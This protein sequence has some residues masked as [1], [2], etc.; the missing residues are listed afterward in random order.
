MSEIDFAFQPALEQAKRIRQKE[1][2]PLELLDFYLERIE[3]Y[4]SRVGSY[5]TVM[6]ELAR[7]DAQAKTEQLAATND[8]ASLPPFFG[9]PLPIKDLNAVAQMPCSAGVAALRDQIPEYE[10]GMVTKLR[11]AGFVLLGKTATSQL[12]SMPYTE[13]DGFPPT[14]NP[15]H[16]EHTPGGSSGGAAAA[17][18]AG[19][20]PVAQGSDGGGSIRIPS[21]CCG[22]LG[23][24]PSRGRISSAPVGDRLHGM[25]TDGPIA[26]TVA[27]AAAML[28]A[29]SGYIWGD[30]Y[31][32]GQ[33]NPSFWEATHQATG[34]LRIAYAT[35]MPGL[36]PASDIAKQ[37]VLDT[38]QRLCELGHEATEA[39]PDF[40]GLVEPFTTIFAAAVSS[41][42]MAKSALEPINRMLAE[43]GEQI[44]AGEYLQSIRQL[45]ILAR[46]IVG[47][48]QDV[49]VLVLPVL[50]HPPIRVGEWSQLP[51][52]EILDRITRWI[53]PC[54]PF[55]ATGQPAI[56]LP[57]GFDGNGLPVSVQL[58]GKPAAEATLIAVASQLEAAY[59]WYQYYP[60]AFAG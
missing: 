37:A 39:C 18:A 49:D 50:L 26:R 38:T 5:F 10:D 58:V 51:L 30:P 20:S 28:D 54:P 44:S 34:S 12:G 55:N 11:Q 24:K 21:A 1:L 22:L 56:A 2:S 41:A 47:F 33:P 35:S 59:P 36:P 3:R 31:W 32:L 15:W 48:F 57:A 4:D 60:E 17:V 43:K 45:Q 29:M 14:R 8:P 7:R 40:Q 6:P 42:G 23:I 52:E 25:A 46:Q 13:P 19:L 27:D 9:V 53:A 16:L